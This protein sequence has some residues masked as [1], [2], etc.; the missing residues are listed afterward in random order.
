MSGAAE[1]AGGSFGRGC[2]WELRPVGRRTSGG[3]AVPKWVG[4]RSAAIAA[5]RIGSSS[6]RGLS[7]GEVG[8]TSRR[9]SEGGV[10]GA[11]AGSGVVGSAMGAD[12]VS[13]RRRRSAVLKRFFSLA[14]DRPLPG[15]AQ[16]PPTGTRRASGA[17]GPR[18]VG[19]FLWVNL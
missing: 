11:G 1:A 19:A 15:R 14:I 7:G 2:R 17:S 13:S 3:V 8:T 12:G 9:A 18:Q 6:G 10:G 5:S 16:R 4:F